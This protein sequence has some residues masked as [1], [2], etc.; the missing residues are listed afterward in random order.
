MNKHIK[1]IELALKWYQM[2]GIDA[3][4]DDQTSVYIE[5]DNDISIM[6]SSSEI[7]FRADLY[8]GL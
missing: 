8:K 6:V 1:E 5:M 4:V 7:S 3:Y 2:H